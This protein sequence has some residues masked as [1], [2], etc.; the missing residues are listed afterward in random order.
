LIYGNGLVR[1][2]IQKS[3]IKKIRLSKN[4]IYMYSARNRNEELKGQGLLVHKT[5]VTGTM[6][7]L[8]WINSR[9]MLFQYL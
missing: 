7:N 8:P 2:I 1:Y 9:T 6:A 3:I 5:I 4:N